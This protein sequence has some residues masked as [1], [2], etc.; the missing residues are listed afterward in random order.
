ME[1]E[2]RMTLAA[3]SEYSA[4]SVCFSDER[5]VSRSSTSR[6]DPNLNG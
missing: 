6:I 3:L 2:A 5:N 4:V 1:R